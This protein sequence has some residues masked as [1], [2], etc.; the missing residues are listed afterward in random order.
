M[1]HLF[2]SAVRDFIIIMKG[3]D[4]L[5]K[6]TKQIVETILPHDKLTLPIVAGSE[7]F[8]RSLRSTAT[9]HILNDEGDMKLGHRY[10]QLLQVGT[11]SDLFTRWL[12][13]VIG[14]AI[15]YLASMN[16]RHSWWKTALSVGAGALA[17]PRIIK[18]KPAEKDHYVA[19][20]FFDPKEEATY[21]VIVYAEDDLK[22]KLYQLPTAP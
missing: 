22:K 21:S 1:Y 4:H 6:E 16:R 12:F 13:P 20:T 8:T 3:S 19:M 9:L 15:G 11:P 2:F 14:G 7:F 18:G 17:L 10:V 5:L